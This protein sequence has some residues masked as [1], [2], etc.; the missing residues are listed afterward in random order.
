M[1]ELHLWLSL[2]HI[3]G[4]GLGYCTAGNIPKG[5]VLLIEGSVCMGPL[6]S[7]D[8][9]GVVSQFIVRVSTTGE[10]LHVLYPGNLCVAALTTVQHD[11]DGNDR[12]S[13][14]TM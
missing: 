1:F 10:R 7:G 3:P 9:H 14:R 4:Q 8:D 5:T 13:L 2:V 6:T 12:S 11:E